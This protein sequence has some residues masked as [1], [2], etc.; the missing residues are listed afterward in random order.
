MTDPYA[1]SQPQRPRVT[2]KPYTWLNQSH[3]ETPGIAIWHK[4]GIAGH[5]TSREARALADQLHDL[6]D[7]VDNGTTSRPN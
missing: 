6:A 3:P 5:L 2:A 4:K 1:G 7:A